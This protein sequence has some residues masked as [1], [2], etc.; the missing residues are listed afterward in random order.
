[1]ATSKSKA[2]NYQQ[3]KAELDAVLETLQ[4]PD[5]DVD[6]AVAGYERGLTLIHQLESYLQTAENHIKQLPTQQG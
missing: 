1:M 2:V 6:A 3:L 5:T 4:Q